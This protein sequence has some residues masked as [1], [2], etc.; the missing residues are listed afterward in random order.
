MKVLHAYT[1]E[2]PSAIGEDEMLPFVATRMDFEKMLSKISQKSQ[3]PYDR[4]HVWD[5][6]LKATNEHTGKSNK[7]SQAGADSS[8]EVTR[9]KGVQ[10]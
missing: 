10:W 8:V 3:A 6:K 7:N 9:G 1:V 2:P 5:L 4:T